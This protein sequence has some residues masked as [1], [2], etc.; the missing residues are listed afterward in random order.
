MTMNAEYYCAG[1]HNLLGGVSLY[2]GGQVYHPQCV[3]RAADTECPECE[4]KDKRIAKLEEE[5]LFYIEKDGEVAG[6]LMEKVE[7]QGKVIAELEAER[8]DYANAGLRSHK[9]CTL[10]A[11]KA[12]AAL[13]EEK[14]LYKALLY[15]K[16][17]VE[18]T[19]RIAELEVENKRLTSLLNLRKLQRA[20]AEL[21]ER[22]AR[23]CETCEQW[24]EGVQ[25]ACDSNVSVFPDAIS[26]DYDEPPADFC[27]N[28]WTRRETP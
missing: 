14:R 17:G 20:E 26:L 2:I 25:Q 10:R 27:C 6:E 9:A 12:E 22:E 8:D 23:C 18:N 11:E 5:N 28:R 21:A 4:V 19:C 24:F 13:E 3:P 7:Q 15:G 1:C 16:C